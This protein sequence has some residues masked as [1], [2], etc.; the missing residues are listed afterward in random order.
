[1]C[2]SYYFRSACIC[3]SEADI[4]KTK[5]VKNSLSSSMIAVGLSYTIKKQRKKITQFPKQ[6]LIE[7]S[8]RRGNKDKETPEYS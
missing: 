1:M 5:L 8:L 2:E 7:K 4:T 6:S 3:L